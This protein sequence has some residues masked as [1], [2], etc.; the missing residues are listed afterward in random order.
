LFS[1]E[2]LT[3]V[4]EA[5]RPF[6]CPHSESVKVLSQGKQTY[7]D[8]SSLAPPLHAPI[9][10]DRIRLQVRK[11]LL[12]ALVHHLTFYLQSDTLRYYCSP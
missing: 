4:K 10:K 3:A 2:K 6:F 8:Y 7:P 11:L 5:L 9:E 1:F 12:H